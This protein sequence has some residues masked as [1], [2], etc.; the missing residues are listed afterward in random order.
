MAFWSKIRGTFETIF[1]IGKNG[2]QIRNSSG[3]LEARDSSDAAY[4]IMRGLDPVG[5]QDFVT[6]TYFD[7]NNAAAQGLTYVSLALSTSGVVSVGTIPNNATIRDVV[8]KVSSAY[9]GGA[10]W[11][12]ARTGGGASIMASGDNDALTVGEYHVPQVTSWGSTGD[13]T[14][15]ATLTGTPSSGAATLLIGYV[16]PTSIN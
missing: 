4:A 14:V 6:K 16:T 1:Q 3:A 10:T 5:A 2:P 15:T 13:P 8:L 12:F 7:T 11:A 9:N